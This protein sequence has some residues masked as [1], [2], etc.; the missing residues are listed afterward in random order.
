[1]WG[2]QK[3]AIFPLSNQCT[4]TLPLWLSPGAQGRG[5]LGLGSKYSGSTRHRSSLNPVVE[6]QPREAGREDNPGEPGE[7]R[8]HVATWKELEGSSISSYCQV[9]AR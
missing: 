4:H 3:E 8:G 6:P 2:Q 1:M 5:N 7:L 9:P